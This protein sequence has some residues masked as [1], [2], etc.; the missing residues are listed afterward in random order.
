MLKI[1]RFYTHVSSLI[2]LIVWLLILVS[3]KHIGKS[4]YK[5]KIGKSCKRTLLFRK[6]QKPF[7]T[8]IF[9]FVAVSFSNDFL[10]SFKELV[11]IEYVLDYFKIDFF[12]FAVIDM[13]QLCFPFNKAS[14]VTKCKK[15]I[16][17]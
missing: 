16:S 9:L 11:F 1:Y 10:D 3:G 8:E 15:Y 12:L 6:S 7:K 13:S 4:R 2:L 5:K 14:V 17:M